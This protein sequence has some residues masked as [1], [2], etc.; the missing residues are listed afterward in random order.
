MILSNAAQTSHELQG[1]FTRTAR[2]APSISIVHSLDAVIGRQ[3]NPVGH[4]RVT[5]GLNMHDY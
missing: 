5:R 3:A 4:V 2:V 1:T